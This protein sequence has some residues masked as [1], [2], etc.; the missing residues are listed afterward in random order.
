MI[1]NNYVIP[2]TIVDGFFSDPDEVRAFA[3]EQEYHA[4]SFHRW[5]GKRTK[6]LHELNLEL[7]EY[8]H[9]KFLNLFYPSVVGASYSYTAETY[10]QLI[11]KNYTAGWVHADPKLITLL[12]YLNKNPNKN[13]GTVIYSQKNEY[14]GVINIEKKKEVYRGDISEAEGEQYRLANNNRFEE[15]IVVK[16]RFNRLLA[17]DCDLFHGVTEYASDEPRLT[18]VSF[19]DNLSVGKYPIQSMKRTG[20]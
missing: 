10:F 16:N 15:E 4:D 12:I 20:K 11:D 3:L 1:M 14:H 8:V 19:I 13:A 7:F 5:P 2:T 17:F 6:W 18:L 9:N